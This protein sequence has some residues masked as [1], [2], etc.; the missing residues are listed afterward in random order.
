[1]SEVK[2]ELRNYVTVSTNAKLCSRAGKMC[3]DDA[4]R[5]AAVRGIVCD[6]QIY[7]IFLI[8]VGPYK[9]LNSQNL[10]PPRKVPCSTEKSTS[11]NSVVALLKINLIQY[12][13][14]ISTQRDSNPPLLANQAMIIFGS[15]LN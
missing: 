4:L 12:T 1:M 8:Q 13:S 2:A 5:E 15:I 14:K 9:L 3:Y 10:P 11:R 6:K 7:K